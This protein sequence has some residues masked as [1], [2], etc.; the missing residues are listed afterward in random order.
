MSSKNDAIARYYARLGAYTRLAGLFGWGGGAG[1]LAVRRALRGPDGKIS[2]RTT[3]ALVADAAGTLDA[4]RI[5][6]AGCG[7]GGLGLALQ[8]KFG[9]RLH[10]ITLSPDQA[11]RATLAAWKTGQSARF[12]VASYDD[13]LP[14]APYDLIV[15]VESLAHSRDL[16]RSI[17]NLARGL[18]GGGKLIV[19]DD[20]RVC[21]PDDPDARDFVEGWQTPSFHSEAEWRA[22]FDATAMRVDL[23]QDLSPLMVHRDPVARRTLEILNAATSFLIPP[24]R[25]LLASHRGGLALERL[26][27]RGAARYALFAASV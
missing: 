1:D 23:F 15:A 18:D 19:V 12:T 13:P 17:A 27:A 14:E 7:L 16:K 11:E 25:P 26:H 5:L 10:G 20:I 22:A 8:E 24:L 2:P 9:G 4:P 6:D 21:D 3:E